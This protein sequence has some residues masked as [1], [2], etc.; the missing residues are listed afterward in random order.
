MRQSSAGKVPQKRPLQADR[1]PGQ[2]FLCCA[3]GKVVGRP[4][5]VDRGRSAPSRYVAV[6]NVPQQIVR[7]MRPDDA[8]AMRWRCAADAKPVRLRGGKRSETLLH[9]CTAARAEPL[10][11]AAL[12][13]LEALAQ[14]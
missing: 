10:R 2:R 12:G 5:C 7:T 8:R 1:G 9:P 14:P 3:A 13:A 4:R 6:A 11:I